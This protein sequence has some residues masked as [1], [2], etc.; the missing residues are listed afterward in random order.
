MQHINV[1]RNTNGINFSKRYWIEDQNGAGLMYTGEF[2]YHQTEIVGKDKKK[3]LAH[4]P[5]PFMPYD[6]RFIKFRSFGRALKFLRLLRKENP[7]IEKSHPEIMNGRFM[8]SFS[9]PTP[10]PQAIVPKSMTD[11]QKIEV[12]CPPDIFYARRG[13]DAH[14]VFIRHGGHNL[15]AFND[16]V[17]R[18]RKGKYDPRDLFALLP[19]TSRVRV[20][21]DMIDINQP[22]LVTRIY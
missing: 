19:K 6:K 20:I 13:M 8:K 3:Y 12:D 7:R 4:V 17:R 11:L 5:V 21:E 1:S 2:A 9:I 10:Q 18:A 15:R 16:C 22:Q 14:A